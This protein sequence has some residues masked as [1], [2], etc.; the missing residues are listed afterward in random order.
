MAVEMPQWIKDLP[1]GER[2]DARR[3]FLLRTAA[4]HYSRDGHLKALSTGIGL[5]EGTLATYLSA[6]QALTAEIAIKLEECLGRKLFPR[7]LWR[8][9]LFDLKT[10]K[11]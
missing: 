4:L 3:R 6:G 5:A 11:R 9:D 10:A 7:E 8:P 2:E 1:D